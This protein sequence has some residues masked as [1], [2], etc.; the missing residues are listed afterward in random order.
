MLQFRKHF[1]MADVESVSQFAYLRIAGN[2]LE[3]WKEMIHAEIIAGRPVILTGTDS[4]VG[5]GHGYV[6]DGLNEEGTFD[7]VVHIHVYS[8]S[9]TQS[10]TYLYSNA[11]TLL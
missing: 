6:L 8:Y 1:L 2:T 3:T 4:K 9:Y 7:S 11:Y 5:A 10:C